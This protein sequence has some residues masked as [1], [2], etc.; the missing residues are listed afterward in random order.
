ML[1]SEIYGSYFRMVAAILAE[2]GD[3][4][5]TP[6]K[7][8][9]LVQKE[10]F[11]E[12]TL[13]I[14]A[15]LR[16]GSWPLLEGG[17]RPVLQHRPTMPLTLLQKR[18]MKA[19][20]ADPRISL[21][22]PSAA[23]LE[24]VEPLFGPDLFVWFDRHADGEPYQDLRYIQCFRTACQA[25]REKRRLQVCFVSQGGARHT[26]NRPPYRL[27]YSSKDDK[28]RLLSRGNARF[29]TVNMAGVCSC[30]LLEPAESP[31]S[32]SAEPPLARMTLLLR[33]ERNGLERILLHF[34]IL[35]RRPES[36][37]TTCTSFG[38]GMIS[39]MRASF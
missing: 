22:A 3:G 39:R 17:L 12:S 27:E 29:G 30:R 7:I 13:S 5:L 37:R 26:F 2:A 8:T 24:D 23:G 32:P 21:F 36:W 14:P 33:D 16:S 1:F 10:A 35:K 18:W 15:A 11:A 25:I 19:L 6:A 4:S 38:S 31:A 9:R 28:F 34:P 20:L